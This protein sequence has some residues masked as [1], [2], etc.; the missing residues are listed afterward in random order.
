MDPMTNLIIKIQ[1]SNIYV[2]Q[3][4]NDPLWQT[5]IVDKL[6]FREFCSQFNNK[7]HR[8]LK[9]NPTLNPNFFTRDK[10]LDIDVIVEVLK[11]DLETFKKDI[12]ISNSQIN[13][14]RLTKNERKQLKCRQPHQHSKAFLSTKPAR[15][16]PTLPTTSKILMKG[17]NPIPPKKL[18]TEQQFPESSRSLTAL[19]HLLS[20]Q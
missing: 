18:A 8:I 10:W 4:I 20:S 14:W 2:D 7:W 1:S 13:S 12:K 19:F 6:S 3:D 15:T 17:Q 9:K 11:L 5:C 16:P